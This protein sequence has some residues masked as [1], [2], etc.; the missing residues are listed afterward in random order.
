MTSFP[1]FPYF[2]HGF[3]RL[4][5]VKKVPKQPCTAR[6]A[7]LPAFVVSKSVHPK[8]KYLQHMIL[9]KGIAFLLLFIAPF[10]LFSQ[11]SSVFTEANLAYKRGM[12]FYNQ[13]LYGLAQ[14]EFRTAMDMLRPVNEPAWEAVKTDAELHHAK[15]AVRLEQ[16][17]A[18]KQVFDF[19]RNHA[20]SP[21]ASQAALEIGDF[22][23]DKRKYDQALEYYDM[24]PLDAAS[25]A[26]RDEI[27]FKQGYSYFV[28]K[29]FPQAKTAFSGLKENTRSEWYYPANYYYGCC[30]FFEGKYDDAAKAFQRCE[31]SDKYDRYVPYYITQ[32]YFAKKQYDLVISYGGV[33][34]KDENLR[35]RPELNQ[36]VGQAY[37]EKG[38]FK[39]ALPYLEY[40]ATNG[41]S[42]R[43]ADYYQLGYAQYQNGYY[44][45]AIENFEQLSKEDTLFAQNGLYHLGDCYLRTD[46]KFAARNAF[47]Q[48]ANLNTNPSVKEDALFN[49][50]KLSYE[51]KYDR[52]ALNALQ[53]IPTTSR[54]YEDAQALMSA[55]FLNTRDYDRAIATLEAVKNRTPRLN[56]TYQQVCYLRGLQLYQNNQKD[57]ARRFF[58]KSLEN[59][60][61]KRTAA[62]CSFWLG[63][64]SNEAEEYNFSKNHMAAFLSQARIYTDLPEESSLNMGNYIQGYNYLKLNDYS[65]ALANF[66]A[67]VD[68]IKRNLVTIQSEQIKTAIL[69]DAILRA[70]DCHFKRNE[71]S[72]ALTYYNEAITRKNEGFEYAIY[73]KAII[74]GLQ[75]RPLDKVITLE[76]LV[77][78]YPNSRYADDALFQIGDTYT[79]MGRLAEAMA[80]LRRLVTDFRGRSPL[81]NDALLKLGLI[82]YNQGNTSA[83]LSYYKQ[84][85]TNNPE[86][87]EAKDALA[88]IEEIYV[89]DLNRPDEYF[90]FLETIPGY[91]VST[92]ARDSVTYYS[93]EIQYQDGRLVQAIDGFTNY[94]AR[95]PNGRYTL[96]AYYYRAECYSNQVISKY[97]MALKDY[98]TVVGRGISKFYPK[99]SE[100]ASLLAYN[101]TKDYPAA[102][103]YARKWEES[104][105]T[106]PSRFEAQVLIMR[107]AYET[108]NSAVL[109]EYAQKVATSRLASPEQVATANY[110]LGKM[111][112]DRGNFP[113]AMPYLQ[114][115]TQSSTSEIMAESYHLQ[116]QILYRQRNYTAAED[117]ISTANQ[118]SAGYDDWI[119][120]NLIL[121]SD[122]YADQNDKNSASAA[123]EAVLENYKGDPAII[124]LAREK[125]NKLNGITPNNQPNQPSGVRG[126]DMLDLD[127][128]N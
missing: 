109:T 89:R 87:S 102:L 4:R 90:A 11:Q 53:R 46:N 66:R 88:A 3:A 110:Y 25:G 111:A 20:P 37:F 72:N 35:K 26:L 122:V 62:L 85:F 18:E 95:Y 83:A 54:Y 19:L 81:I 14:K 68:G 13:R 17:E 97:D 31:K 82:S 117:L 78:R 84:V 93:A 56:E 112:Y 64:I 91:N 42:L 105:S 16:P 27:R 70:G 101:Y 57:E 61:N 2:R 71:Y 108:N 69:G 113:S 103:E 67:A 1:G 30:A 33:K 116:A 23:F 124:N 43:A 50:A 80:P 10:L 76:D 126:I 107:T 21:E 94:L 73:Q 48:A 75:K 74:Q 15:C 106:E 77:T 6:P 22:Y 38:D 36:L 9:Q 86:N 44:K 99:S 125:Y 7:P 47:G 119:A 98:A 114:R 96:E 51:L 127:E 58:N 29:R 128:G 65:N 60:L 121:L 45:P 79:E 28:T 118:A 92:A 49:Y 34:A 104:A 55:V 32:I 123:L 63:S 12:D 115:V 52:D 24:A 40:A 8:S 120:R 39:R 59:P 100:K 41:V 5:F